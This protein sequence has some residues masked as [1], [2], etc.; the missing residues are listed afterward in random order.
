MKN[1][2]FMALM[3]TLFSISLILASHVE[4][5]A[6]LPGTVCSISED[7]IVGIGSKNNHDEVRK[8]LIAGDKEGLTQMF[9]DGKSCALS[10]GDQLLVLDNG[11]FVHQVRVKSGTCKGAAAWVPNEYLKCR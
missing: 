6:F 8:L 9:F 2:I 4:T 11:F 10:K 5:H 1:N 7:I 3:I